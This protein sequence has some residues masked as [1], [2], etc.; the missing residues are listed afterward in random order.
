MS[1][2]VCALQPDLDALPAGD[3]TEIGERG[4]TLSGGQQARVALAR[5]AFAPHVDA[6]LL[7]DVLAAVDARVG[8]PLLAAA[9]GVRVVVWPLRPS[10]QDTSAIVCDSHTLPRHRDAHR[11]RAAAAALHHRGS[12]WRF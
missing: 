5:A 11:R 8:E 9:A 3:Q 10:G 6:Y 12:R 1:H 2:Q 4:I 7:D